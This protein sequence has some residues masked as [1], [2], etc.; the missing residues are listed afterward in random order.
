MSLTRDD[1]EHVRIRE[2]VTSL[3]TVLLALRFTE[4]AREQALQAERA[5]DEGRERASLAREQMLIVNPDEVILLRAARAAFDAA[6]HAVVRLGIQA[7]QSLDY[8]MRTTTTL[9][10]A[11]QLYS[12]SAR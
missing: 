3:S 9:E 6:S 4:L 12:M 7:G 8:L 10:G 11:I 1:D 5:L 2:R